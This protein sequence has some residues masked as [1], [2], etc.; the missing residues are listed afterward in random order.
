MEKEEIEKKCHEI[1]EMT[2]GL[3][4]RYIQRIFTALEKIH[5][6]SAAGLEMNT[7]EITEVIWNFDNY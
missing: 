3:P 5:S 1:I 2:K 4:Y 7:A 6:R